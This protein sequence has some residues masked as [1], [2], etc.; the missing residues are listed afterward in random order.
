[1][2][3]DDTPLRATTRRSVQDRI[4]LAA[5]D[6]FVEQGYDATTV[7]QIAGTVGMSERTFFRYFATKHDVLE[8][9]SAH[10]RERVAA[11]LAARPASEPTWVAVR[12]AFDRYVAET[13]EEGRA[14]P[15][16]GVIYASPTLHARHLLRLT[17]WTEAIVLALRARLDR[18]AES[19]FRATVQAAVVMTCFETARQAWVRSGGQEPFGDLLDTAMASAAELLDEV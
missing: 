11:D 12:R 3:S 8:H 17:Q 6:L 9:V 19:D 18:T 5:I 1:M 7:S 2:A 16:L 13:V 14:L 10:W 4:T 15:L